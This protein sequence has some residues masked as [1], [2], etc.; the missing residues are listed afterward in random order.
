ML[1]GEDVFMKRSLNLVL[2]V[3][4]L[5]IL[6]IGCDDKSTSAEHVKE[7]KTINIQLDE[8][9]SNNI[10]PD[11]L[12][13]SLEFPNNTIN[14]T[15]RELES[16]MII[17]LTFWMQ[18]EG[19]INIQAK[20]Y[21]GDFE[22]V[23]YS[24]Y[25]VN[26]DLNI[27]LLKAKYYHQNVTL[28]L[29]TN[30]LESVEV[31]DFYNYDALDHFFKEYQIENVDLKADQYLNTPMKFMMNHSI[32]TDLLNED[33]IPVVHYSFGDYFNPITTCNNAFGCYNEYLRTN[34]EEYLDWF[35]IN[36]DWLIN[37]KD[38]NGLLR[39]QF[40]W[41]HENA[42]LQNGWTSAMA[43]GQ[44][45][46]VMCMAYHN[47]ADNKYLQA[48]EVIF[49]TMHKNFGDSWNLFIDSEDYLWYEEYPNSDF[50][51]VLNGKLFGMWG[52][53]DYYCI[54]RDNDALK[55]LQGGIASVIDNYQ[56]WDVDGQ[57]GSSYCTHS[58][59]ISDYHWI[60]KRQL[61]E[62]RDMFGIND[63]DIILKTFTNE[64]SN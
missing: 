11:S 28:K 54:T 55:L 2:I 52:L 48:A 47:S 17:E 39:Y 13:I 59:T 6:F 63:F 8:L 56:I 23:T 49:T 1:T 21:W 60:H 5:T 46:A 15:Y 16:N 62:Y 33:L 9:Y 45:L 22:K 30:P 4:I 50:C 53:W 51:H 61:A 7:V 64:R 37:Y 43:Q 38:E 12:I 25:R 26:E 40:D 58:D 29:D 31:S 34:D 19:E 44:T 3:F 10:E 36:A 20:L 57:D 14:N 24:K 35:Y 42:N 32:L 41:I 27:G 18:L